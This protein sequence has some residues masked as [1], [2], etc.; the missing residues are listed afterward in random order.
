MPIYFLAFL[1]GIMTILSPCILP[2]VPIV[3]ASSLGKSKLKPLWVT[4]GLVI[5][6]S[7]FGIIFGSLG[8]ILGISRETARTI[9]IILILIL[10]TLLLF[11]TLLEKAAQIFSR[12]KIIKTSQKKQ[13]GKW[14]QNLLLG[15][16]LGLAWVPCAGPIL[17]IILGFTLLSGN[18]FR[19]L[20]LM[21]IYGIGIAIPLLLIGYLGNTLVNQINWLKKHLPT[22]Q[23]IAGG[24]IIIIGIAMI[25]RLDQEIQ[26]LFLT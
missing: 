3:L 21:L 22:I 16:A 12:I 1:A 4:L 26:R 15:I 2:I 9:G 10:G 20:S 7:L 8:S 25:F 11:P 23:K 14:W 6:F 24:V 5:S 13:E 17:G 18:F 19:S